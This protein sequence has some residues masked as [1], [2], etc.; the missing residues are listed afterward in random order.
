LTY[1]T[2]TESDKWEEP[3][4]DENMPQEFWELVVLVAQNPWVQR[5]GNNL[6]QN[7]TFLSIKSLSNYLTNQPTNQLRGPKS[8][9][10]YYLS[11]RKSTNSPHILRNPKVHYR[12]HSRP[13]LVSILSQLDPGRALILFSYLYY[14]LILPNHLRLCLPNSHFPSHFPT[15]YQYASLFTFIRVTRHTLVVTMYTTCLN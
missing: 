3:A 13:P 10:R 14:I 8:F 2:A 15:Q 9:L 7:W 5:N 11:L 12:V 1:V 4:V 6:D